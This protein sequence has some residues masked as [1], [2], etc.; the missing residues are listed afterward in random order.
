MNERDL[1]AG[2]EASSGFNTLDDST[3]DNE[4]ALTMAELKAKLEHEQQNA[5]DGAAPAPELPRTAGPSARD[6]ELLDELPASDHHLGGLAG[7]RAASWQRWV[8]GVVFATLAIVSAVLLI[9][10]RH[11]DRQARL[12]PV[13]ELE[14]TIAPGSPR[15]MTYSEGKFRIMLSS[16]AP[17]VN[18]VHL[19]DRDITLARGVDR[20]SFKVEVRDGKTVAL[21]VLTG[22]LVETLTRDDAEPL[23]TD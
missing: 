17:A 20:A 22:E 2:S 15:E 18:L 19:P 6:D 8:I 4:R 16:E 10:H 12:H 13:P 1:P 3:E 5:T 11:E 21:E 9:K 7:W 23:L 14:A